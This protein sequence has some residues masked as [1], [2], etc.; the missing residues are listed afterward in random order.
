VLVNIRIRSPLL[1]LMMLLINTTTPSQ[2]RAAKTLYYPDGFPKDLKYELV[3]NAQG[4]NAKHK[5]STVH[6]VHR[7]RQHLLAGVFEHP[8]A[9]MAR[10]AT[11][12]ELVGSDADGVGNCEPGSVVDVVG[13]VVRLGRERRHRVGDMMYSYRWVELRGPESDAAC[14]MQ[15]F[16][17]SQQG[18]FDGMLPGMVLACTGVDVV[19]PKG[20]GADD[21]GDES[22]LWLRTRRIS[23]YTAWYPETQSAESSRPYPAVA[24]VQSVAEWALTDAAIE[25]VRSE[26]MVGGFEAWVPRRVL[27]AVGDADNDRKIVPLTSAVLAAK[28]LHIAERVVVAV[29]AKVPWLHFTDARS[30]PASASVS[31]DG[32]GPADA[33]EVTQW[34]EVGKRPKKKQRAAA[35]SAKTR[36][37]GAATAEDTNGNVKS[38]TGFKLAVAP[39]WASGLDDKDD[40]DGAHAAMPSLFSSV[41]ALLPTRFN[42]DAL[43]HT[44]VWTVALLGLNNNAL[45][46]AATPVLRLP[47]VR[48]PLIPF[49]QIS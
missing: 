31:S 10:F 2:V 38:G 42:G 49:V 6:V 28:E 32:A 8:L 24:E 45:L 17:T 46:R 3:L 36:R 44:G 9:T 34:H 5:A 16:S 14:V 12:S 48:R 41:S 29:S 7:A 22:T 47:T 33:G 27:A 35:S 11:P 37:G 1:L 19:S 21:A 20:S 25:T 15:L 13:M 26:G 23:V 30:S 18:E 39:D 4:P 40:D 43:D